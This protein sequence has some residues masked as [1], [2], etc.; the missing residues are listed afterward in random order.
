M[1]LTLYRKENV[2]Y[3]PQPN[4]VQFVADDTI[5]H[6]DLTRTAFMVP[7]LADG[8]VIM[9]NNRRRGIEFPG[10]HIDPGETSCAAAHRE[11]VEETGYWVNVIKSIGYLRMTS[12]GEVPD[13]WQYPHP[14]SYQQ[15]FAGMVKDNVV[16]HVNEECYGPT[17][18][19]MKE[20]LIFLNPSRLAL[21]KLALKVMLGVETG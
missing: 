19:P 7:L 10:G 8:S 14:L 5:Q 12:E 20:A 9:A 3:L 1:K 4:Y 16:Y 21:Y 18:M 15:F 13:D 11:C 2:S 6:P 17:V